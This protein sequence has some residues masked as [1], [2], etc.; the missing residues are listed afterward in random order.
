[1]A[2]DNTGGSEWSSSDGIKDGKGTW[3]GEMRMMGMNLKTKTNVEMSAK[4]LKVTSDSSLDGKKWVTGAFEMT[5][6]K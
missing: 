4:E 3:T 6:K 1:M 2:V 5:C